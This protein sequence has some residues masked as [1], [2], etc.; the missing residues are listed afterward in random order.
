MMR[1]TAAGDEADF[2]LS[3][4]AANRWLRIQ[5]SG[6]AFPRQSEVTRQSFCCFY[7]LTNAHAENKKPNFVCRLA[8]HQNL[9]FLSNEF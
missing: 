8:A 4:T 7:R 5:L 1:A 6:D 2:S 3:V 9:E